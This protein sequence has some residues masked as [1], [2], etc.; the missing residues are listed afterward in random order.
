M[1]GDDNGTGGGSGSGDELTTSEA[2]G[3]WIRS[4][5]AA[6]DGFRDVADATEAHR[7]EHG[8][9]TYAGGDGPLLLVLAA[10]IRP[11]RV[12]EIGTALGYSALN[13]ASGAG[14]G[15]Q[16]DTVERDPVHVELARQHFAANGL[17]DRITV[18]E[19]GDVDVLA[20]FGNAIYDLVFYDAA[21][22]TPAHLE[23]FDRLL[24]PDGVL[25]SSNLFL[26]QYAPDMPG[27][28]DGARYRELLFGDAWR[29]AFIGGKA[30]SVRR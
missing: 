23:A 22:P 3:E 11:A 30:L 16:L 24:A 9:D 8:C 20:G 1:S 15:S 19:G 18:H 17:A 10:A 21:V 4:R 7:V 27:L 29:T 14:A 26:G 2:I 5:V 13:L 25:I 6:T 12:L 28:A